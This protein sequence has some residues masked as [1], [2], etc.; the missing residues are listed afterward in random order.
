M[1]LIKIIANN[2]EL[3]FVKETLSIKKENNALNRDFKVSYS[4]IPFLIIENA[5]TK[6]ALGTRDLSSVKKIKTIDVVVFEGGK[7]YSGELQILSYLNGFRKCNLKYASSLLSIMNKKISEFMP[8]VSVIPGETNPVAFTENSKLPVAGSDNWVAYAKSFVGKIFPEV[9]W[10]FPTMKY[11]NKYGADL[12]IDDPWRKF[13]NSINKFDD[14]G[15]INNS[16]V[17]ASNVCTVENRNVPSPQVFLVS[18]LSFA[19]EN[20][21]WSVKG[22]FINSAFIKRLLM[23]SSKNNISESFPLKESGNFTFGT[24]QQ[25]SV[26]ENNNNDLSYIF[27]FAITAIATTVAGMYYFDY[28]FTEPAYT[29]VDGMIDRKMFQIFLFNEPI[30]TVFTHYPT[31]GAQTYK[32]TVKVDVSAA[33]V[34]MN[35]FVRYYTPVNSISSYSIVKKVTYPVVYYQMHPTI[36]LARYVPDWTFGTYL[37]ALQNMFNLEINFDDLKKQMTIDFNE[38]TISIGDKSVLTKSLDSNSYEQSASDAFLLKYENSDDVALWITKDR[39]ENYDIQT[40][41]FVE[42]LDNKFKFV[43]SLGTAELSEKLDSKNG[44]GL[45]IYDTFSSPYTSDNYLGQTLKIEGS[46]GIYE[47]FWRKCIKFLLNGSAVEMSG[48]FTEKELN[49]IILLKRIFIDNQE[50]L[51]ASTESRETD[52]NNYEVKFNLVSVTF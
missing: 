47:V 36:Q 18:P 17:I 35:I 20:I 39:V 38:E 1:S 28:E 7:K 27:N 5:N 16:Y 37:N 40:S 46:K 10:Q 49:E 26:Y 22:S 2:I 24:L 23:Y 50:Y 12:A 4:S 31:S 13:E 6:K 45:M 33:Q 52:Q 15:L 41:N 48:P 11:A 19:L 25:G 42:R 14:I 30:Y 43:P 9:K 29:A 34:G 51:I 3:D 8:I 32:G 44:V 21:G